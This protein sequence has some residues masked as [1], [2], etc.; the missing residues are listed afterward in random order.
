[1]KILVV[2]FPRSGTSLTHRIFKKHPEMKRMFFEKFMIKNRSKKELIK[3]EKVFSPGV[4]CGEKIIYTR[5][6]V[7]KDG[8]MSVIDYCKKWNE[9]FG[10]EAKIIQPIRHPIDSWTSMKKNGVHRKN[11]EIMEKLYNLYFD[12]IPECTEII[13]SFENCFTFKY[14]NLV[15]N[16]DEV[17]K[18]L[19]S[20]CNLSNFNFDERMKERRVF[21]NKSLPYYTHEKIQDA[22][23]V[24]N[25]FD[26][27]KYEL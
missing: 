19:Y 22:L 2:G 6:R 12:I 10:E 7:K 5:R 9:F 24:F 26:G 1:M 14:E 18:E 13:N 8:S 16:K 25:K 27:A 21:A 23:D 15:M 20:F 11:Q 3:A 4:N 17:V